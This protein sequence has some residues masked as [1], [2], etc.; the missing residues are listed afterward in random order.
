MAAINDPCFRVRLASISQRRC[1]VPVRAAILLHHSH[2]HS[3]VLLNSHSGLIGGSVLDRR[4]N[5]RQHIIR[6]KANRNVLWFKLITGR[7]GRHQNARWIFEIAP[8]RLAALVAA[9]NAL[10]EGPKA[11]LSVECDRI[12]GPASAASPPYVP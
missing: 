8:E 1:K 7:K 9:S 3:L 6:A 5:T 4:G 2:R 12:L 10:G 11:F